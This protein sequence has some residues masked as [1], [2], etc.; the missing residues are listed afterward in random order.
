[1]SGHRT[2]IVTVKRQAATL[3]NTLLCWNMSGASLIEGDVAKKGEK[4]VRSL[5]VLSI[6]I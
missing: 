3:V 1:M 6:Y 5:L 2:S 4:L